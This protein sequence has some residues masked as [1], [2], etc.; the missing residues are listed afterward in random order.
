MTDV[1]ALQRWRGAMVRDVESGI[2]GILMDVVVDYVDP[3]LSRDAYGGACGSAFG[4]SA[5]KGAVAVFIR[6]QG[7]G[8]E[9]VAAPESVRLVE[10]PGARGASPGCPHQ[11]TVVRNGR[12]HCGTCGV[13][14]YL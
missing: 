2:V 3:Q 12:T 7:G 9:Y 6:P 4:A 14:L 5:P 13:R 10:P 11:V 1:A 8:L